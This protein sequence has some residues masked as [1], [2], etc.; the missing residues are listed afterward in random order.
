MVLVNLHNMAVF[1][2]NLKNRFISLALLEKF[3]LVFYYKEKYL[4]NW[5]LNNLYFATLHI[6]TVRNL[7]SEYF[8]G[9]LTFL[10]N[11]HPGK[12]CL[13]CTEVEPGE[14]ANGI[15]DL[16]INEKQNQKETRVS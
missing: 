7:L 12:A 11:L 14:M 6:F 9:V 5:H 1:F 13:L 10:N 16:D 8:A 4:G 15:C 3:C 2:L